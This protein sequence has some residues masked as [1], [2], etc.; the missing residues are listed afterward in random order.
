M[1]GVRDIAA[2]AAGAVGIVALALLLCLLSF[3]RPRLL[4][5]GSF[6]AW[7][8]L[9]LAIA[10]F[11][12]ALFPDSTVTGSFEGFKV[13]GVSAL[14]LVIAIWLAREGRLV[15]DKDEEADKHQEEI[16]EL[17]RQLADPSRS[18]PQPANPNTGPLAGIRR[19]RYQTTSRRSR[20]TVG[21][22]AGNMAEVRNVDVWVNSENTN[23]QMASY[24]DRSI[25]AVIRYFGA[26]RNHAGDVEED[27]VGNLLRQELGN[28]Q[29]VSPG[30]VFVTEPGYLAERGVKRIC[31]VAAVQGEVG[32]GY[33]PVQ[34][35]G[36]CITRVLEE[37]DRRNKA[38]ASLLLRSV[39]FPLLGTGQARANP[40]EVF[41]R[42][43]TAA[44][45]YLQSNETLINEFWFVVYR[46]E[47]LIQCKQVLDGEADLVA[48]GD[49]RP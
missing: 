18:Q 7:S 9:S 48:V 27:V 14:F 15:I 10:L 2:I 46:Q 23:M 28:A 35:L 3:W 42:L 25:S 4:Y 41:P 31:H 37:I 12:F 30:T 36:R 1:D 33:R 34:D 19:Y 13:G 45:T 5:M 11:L 26:R 6:L 17:R 29:T 49:T 22:I 40:Q 24:Y 39:V 20:R 8:L 44:L 21:L 47:E 32:H 16:K 38:D 43:L